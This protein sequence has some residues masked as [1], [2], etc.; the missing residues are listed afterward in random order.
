[1]SHGVLQPEQRK[2]LR[3][4]VHERIVHDLG[5]GD[6]SL[7][8]VLLKL[9]AREIVAVDKETPRARPPDKIKVVK[10][11]FQAY[12]PGDLDVAFLSWPANYY[13]RGLIRLLQK[14]KTVVYLGKNTDGTACGFDEMFA[15]LTKR[16]VAAHVPHPDN[17]LIVY[18]AQTCRREPLEDEY[19]ALHQERIYSFGEL[20]GREV[21]RVGVE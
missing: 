16:Q 17:T 19:A 2:A 14:A 4:F 20:S 13:L 12:T 15:Y 21:L 7:A 9:G 8:R 6:L 5:A 3:P 18:T 11:P 1:M 10:S